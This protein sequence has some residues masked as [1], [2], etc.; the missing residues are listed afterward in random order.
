MTVTPEIKGYCPGARHP[1]ASG[2]GL[3]V[4]AK[5]IGSALSSEQ[6]REI[7]DIASSCGNG[8]I[9]LSQ[10]AQL[11]LRGLSEATLD[12]AL[13]RL[14]AI[15]LLAPDAATESVLNI[16][17]SP[18]AG[19]DAATFDANEL[20]RR[21]ARAI[22]D[23]PTLRALPGKFLF[24]LDDA[25]ALGLADAAADIRLEAFGKRI[26]IVLDGARD[27]AVIVEAEAAIDTALALAPSSRFVKAT[28]SNCGGCACLSP[29]AA[30]IF[31]C[32]KRVSRPRLIARRPE[33]RATSN[34]SARA[35]SATFGSRASA[36]RWD[37]GARAI[38]P[39][40]RT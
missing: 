37:V 19:L 4:R 23:D 11:Q 10:R 8:L 27:R 26:A 18:L 28:T 21:L 31:C 17:A 12:E 33:P 9:D 25:S 13:R 29:R 3:L 16:L 39:R 24:L 35:P 34:F 32:A 2:D 30:P 38:S 7:A 20:A 15:G 1:M 5:I 14:D 6:A 22:A 36:R 40:S